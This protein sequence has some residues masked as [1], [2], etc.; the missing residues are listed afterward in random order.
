MPPSA[1]GSTTNLPSNTQHSINL[2]ETLS[3][4]TTTPSRPTA[5]HKRQAS[6]IHTI[7]DFLTQAQDDDTPHSPKEPPNPISRNPAKLPTRHRVRHFTWSFFTM[8]MATGGIANVIYAVPTAMRFQHLDALGLTYYLL[9]IVLFITAITLISMRFWMFPHTFRASFLHPTESLFVPAATISLGTILINTTQYGVG[10]TGDWLTQT[11]VVLYWFYAALALTLSSS[12]YL[13]LWSTQTFTISQMTPVWIFPAYPLLIVGPFAGQ[14]AAK[15]GGKQALEIIIGGFVLQGIGFMVS[16]MIYSAFL[17]RLMTHKLPR[18]N[19]RPGMFVS[20]GPSGFTIAGIVTMGQRLPAVVSSDF[21]IKGEGALVA[22]I[23]LVAANWAG[24]WLW[25]YVCCGGPRDDFANG[26]IRLAFWFFIVSVGSHV[27]SAY[28]GRI[29]FAM[30]WYSFVFP[31]TAL[32][33]ATFAIDRA[34]DGNRAIQILGC[35]LAMGVVLTWFFVTAM[36]IRAI[37]LRQILWPQKGEDRNEGGW[38]EG[39]ERMRSVDRER[40]FRLRRATLMQRRMNGQAK[41]SQTGIEPDT[42]PEEP[43]PERKKRGSRN[44]GGRE[45]DEEK[46]LEFDR[47]DFAIKEARRESGFGPMRGRRGRSATD[48]VV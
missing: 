17:Y 8:T 37:I 22:K 26:G 6:F 7:N 28:K 36:M 9:N 24:L 46:V 35:T 4:T 30:T 14:L 15:V 11:M 21:M 45:D 25:G 43:K 44:Q 33:T 42:I 10:R 31:N 5:Q 16:L 34:L 48:N 3:S 13:I 20:V 38:V 1:A 2:T 23:S 29:H 32:T 19:V 47:A 12:I 27:S 39:D 41:L 18:E 40:E